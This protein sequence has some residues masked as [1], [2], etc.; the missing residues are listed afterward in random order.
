MSMNLLSMKFV[1]QVSRIPATGQ[2]LIPSGQSQDSIRMVLHVLLILLVMSALARRC[3]SAGYCCYQQKGEQ[4]LGHH[5]KCFTVIAN[6]GNNE[7][8]DVD[9]DADDDKHSFR[10]GSS[11]DYLDPPPSTST[12]LY[13][14]MNLKDNTTITFYFTSL[15]I[16]LFQRCGI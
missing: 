4:C 9:I 16:A 1:V 3:S 6:K 14:R 5:L 15:I 10:I 2:W 7:T 8:V 13:V 11:F 12:P